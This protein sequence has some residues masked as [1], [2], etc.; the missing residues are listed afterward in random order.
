VKADSPL[1][2]R[3]V[4]CTETSKMGLGE[5]IGLSGLSIKSMK[6]HP[7]IIPIYV[8]IG[9]GMGLAGFYTARLALKSPEV[10]WNRRTNPEPWNYY[11]DKQH[12]FVSSGRDY[13]EGTPAPKF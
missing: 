13:T 9:M 10:T 5:Q 11:S 7:A 12:K 1:D 4:S 3:I 8:L 2:F 6:K